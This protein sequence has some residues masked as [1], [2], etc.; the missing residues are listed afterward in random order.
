MD[1]GP[2]RVH[3]RA[4]R[5]HMEAVPCAWRG[6]GLMQTRPTLVVS[7]M[8]RKP[9]CFRSH[10]RLVRKSRSR[11]PR[12]AGRIGERRRVNG[13]MACAATHNRAALRAS[14]LFTTIITATDRVHT[15]LGSLVLL[16]QCKD[17]F[18]VCAGIGAG[19]GHRRCGRP[20]VVVVLMRLREIRWDV[21]QPWL[22]LYR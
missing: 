17:V 16:V 15:R 19:V 9:V 5:S 11:I 1:T 7:R 18:E 10:R 20:G 12:T 3:A 4:G 14:L 21:R 22:F 2:D 13:L 6:S 8:H